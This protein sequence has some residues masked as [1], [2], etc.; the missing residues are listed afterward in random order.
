MAPS[1]PIGFWL[2]LLDQLIDSQLE[3]V[4]GEHDVTR[5]QWQLLNL[6]DGGRATR[7]E[8]GNALAPFL[9]AGEPD[10]LGKELSGLLRSGWVARTGDELTLTEQGRLSFAGLGEVLARSRRA[11]AAGVSAEEYHQ[12]LE[13]LQRMA[14]NLGWTDPVAA[15]AS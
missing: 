5:R 10:P 14:R 11:L 2:K 15:P 9:P 8:L 13:V 7:A 12:T 1:R 4:L 6:L 3:A